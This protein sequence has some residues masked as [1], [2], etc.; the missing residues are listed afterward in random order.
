MEIGRK[1]WNLDNAIWALQGRHRDMVHFADYIYTKPYKGMGNMYYLPGR[2]NGEWD[3][4]RVNGRHLDRDK[5]EEF[6][7]KYYKL[8]GWDHRTSWPKLDTLES[9]GLKHVA[10]ALS[11]KAKLGHY[12]KMG[13]VSISNLTLHNVTK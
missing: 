5:F 3:Y 4:I 12:K 6:K 10:E 2:I 9:L 8:E 11:T 13:A 7:T 1:I